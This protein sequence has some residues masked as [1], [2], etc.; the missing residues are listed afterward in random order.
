MGGSYNE[1][2]D[3]FAFGIILYQFI[4]NRLD[5]YT[6]KEY[7][8][9]EN[10]SGSSGGGDS[11]HNS[12]DNTKTTNNNNTTTQNEGGIGNI[13]YRVATDPNFR[14]I[15]PQEGSANEDLKILVEIMKKCWAHKSADRPPFSEICQDLKKILIKYKKIGSEKD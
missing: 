1:K 10:N 5:P 4:F 2:C 12:N 3:V 8:N 14:P 9:H 11:N 15:I 7:S 6:N 13:E